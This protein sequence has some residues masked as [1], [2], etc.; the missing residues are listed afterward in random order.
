MLSLN[1]ISCASICAL[2]FLSLDSLSP[3]SLLSFSIVFIRGQ[4]PS[5]PSHLCAEQ[6]HLS[7]ALLVWMVFDSFNHLCGPPL[8]SFQ[9]VHSLVQSS[10]CQVWPHQCGKRRAGNSFD[11]LVALLLPQPSVELASFAA[12]AYC[13]LT[14]NF[15]SSE[16]PSPSLAAPLPP[17]R[18]VP[19]VVPPLLSSLRFLSAPSS[20]SRCLWMASH[21]SGVSAPVPALHH[22]QSGW[23]SPLS[24]SPCHLWCWTVPAAVLSPG[25]QHR[26]LASSRKSHCCHKPLS[27]LFNLFYI[28]LTVHL[29]ILYLI[30]VMCTSSAF[31]SS[32]DVRKCPKSSL[33]ISFLSCLAE[34]PLRRVHEIF[35]PFFLLSNFSKRKILRSFLNIFLILRKHMTF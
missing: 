31:P 5:E 27:W 9:Q 13:W 1:R 30:Y 16:H 29:T 32:Y 33:F 24:H 23:W 21:S 15:F 4:S 34:E 18:L 20:S 7:G 28:H 14:V 8:D 26:G 3:F 10:T 17:W 22:Q 11:L 35:N 19:A 25:A 6:Y 2:C 12:K